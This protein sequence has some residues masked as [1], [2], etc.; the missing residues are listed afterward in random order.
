[1]LPNCREL[2]VIESRWW[3]APRRRRSA[4]AEMARV[5][6][7][8]IFAVNKDEETALHVAARAGSAEGVRLLLA[9]GAVAD[10]RD[11]RGRTALHL[12]ASRG[13][14][15]VAALIAAGARVD[16]AD[17]GGGTPLHAA[18]LAGARDA[19]SSTRRAQRAGRARRHG[20][21]RRGDAR[22]PRLHA[23]TRYVHESG[24][25][26]GTT[27]RRTSQWHAPGE[28]PPPDDYA[29]DAGAY[30]RDGADA[31]APAADVSALISDDSD[32]GGDGAD[33]ELPPWARD[34]PA[35]AARASP[36]RRA[37][38]A[39]RRGAAERALREAPG[40]GAERARRG[41]EGGGAERARRGPGRTPRAADAARA[42]TRASRRRTRAR[43]RPR[44]DAAERGRLR[45]RRGAPLD[46][47]AGRAPA[48]AG[49][50][51]AAPALPPAL[52]VRD[53]RPPAL[54]VRDVRPPALDARDP[55]DPAPRDPAPR[56]PAPRPAPRDLRRRRRPESEPDALAVQQRHLA[57]WDRFLMNAAKLSLEGGPAK[58]VDAKAE[59]VLAAA[60]GEGPEPRA[61]L[62]RLLHEG[63]SPGVSDEYGRQPLHHAAFGDALDA[64]RILYDCGADVDAADGGGNRPLHVAAARGSGAVL[65]FLLGC[66]AVVDASNHDGD[67]PLHL[68][69]WMGH[70]GC[71]ARL[72]AGTRTPTRSTPSATTL[73]N[74][75]ERSPAAEKRG[76]AVDAAAGFA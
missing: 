47:R 27:R 54:D 67:R 68:A 73:E 39:L 25:P 53:V 3:A 23:W 74:I 16:A 14:A 66:A 61:T 8:T 57:I 59:A 33:E 4:M 1:M 58:R 9:H 72:L 22:P 43:P 48:G 42:G 49:A 32:D 60:A 45:R 52:D 21:P 26:T 34:E 46:R 63:V 7:A 65:D 37:G 36:R 62:A 18:S 11:G 44:P 29:Y 70:G 17:A 15:C 19:R 76:G 40:G 35:P 30:A 31:A 12:A 2:G 6:D 55:R 24:D 71:A 10:A 41:T 50:A 51:R 38:P 56:D 28:D 75:I 69:A 20:A 64:A 5:Q 13:L